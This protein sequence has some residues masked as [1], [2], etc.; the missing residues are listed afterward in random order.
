M[1]TPQTDQC[2]SEIQAQVQALENAGTTV[3]I[4]DAENM[5]KGYFDKIIAL[6]RRLEQELSAEKARAE[7]AEEALAEL[8]DAAGAIFSD[9]VD[10]A[11]DQPFCEV[12]MNVQL[13]KVRRVMRAISAARSS[14]LTNEKP[15][16]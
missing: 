3:C 7:E 6:S 9:F 14:G 5:L 1:N 10:D 16:A 12:Q 11:L 8:K 15:S 2:V 4:D 13:G